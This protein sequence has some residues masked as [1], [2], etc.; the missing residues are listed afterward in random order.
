[1]TKEKTI[2]S[3]KNKQFKNVRNDSQNEIRMWRRNQILLYIAPLQ[4]R[5]HKSI[6]RCNEVMLCIMCSVAF[7]F[8]HFCC[9]YLQPPFTIFIDYKWESVSFITYAD[10]TIDETAVMV[11]EGF[12]KE[13]FV[14]KYRVLYLHFNCGEIL[15]AQLSPTGRHSNSRGDLSMFAIQS[16]KI[17]LG[18]LIRYFR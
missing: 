8:F 7:F 5:S 10:G 11:E 3:D 4:I 15:F 9:C 6:L 18:S 16:M 1:M 2:S 14:K 17:I 12:K 13:A